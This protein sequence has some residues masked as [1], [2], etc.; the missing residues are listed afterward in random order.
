[1]NVTIPTRIT[2]IATTTSVIENI[3]I[4]SYYRRVI[5]AIIMSNISIAVVHFSLSLLSQELLKFFA[6]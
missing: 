1:M 4:I 2:I 5:K 6:F 3:V